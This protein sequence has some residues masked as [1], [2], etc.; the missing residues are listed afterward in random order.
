V[1]VS[2][3]TGVREQGVSGIPSELTLYPPSPNPFNSTTILRFSLPST[4]ASTLTSLRIYGIDGRLVKELV[5]GR[6]EAGY[7]SVNLSAADLPAGLFFLRLE[8]G[9][10]VQVQKAVVVK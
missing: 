5:N 7:H 10:K 1:S 6:L 4:S 8:A 2:K 9:G 3:V